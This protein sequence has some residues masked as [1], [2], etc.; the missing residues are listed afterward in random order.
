LLHLCVEP[1]RVSALGALSAAVAIL[2]AAEPFPCPFPAGI[3]DPADVRRVCSALLWT[4][5][6]S[7][8]SPR[9]PLWIMAKLTQKRTSYF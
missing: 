9:S 1:G 5:V 4:G 3:W 6:R 7:W 8:L 2:W